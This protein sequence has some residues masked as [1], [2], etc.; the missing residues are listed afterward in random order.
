MN[1]KKAMATAPVPSSAETMANHNNLNGKYNNSLGKSSAKLRE[2]LAERV[3]ELLLYLQN[4]LLSKK[5]QERG[6]QLF[7]STL[8]RYLAAKHLGLPL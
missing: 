2:E 5:E 8:R 6:W 3:G 7:G 1:I 4:P